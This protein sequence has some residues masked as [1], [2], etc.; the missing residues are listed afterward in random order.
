MTYVIQISRTGGPEV[1]EYAEVPA[2]KPGPGEALIRHTAV[3]LNFIDTY[4]RS[5]LYKLPLPA[6][7]GNEGAGVVE[8]VGPGVTVVKAGDRV[9]YQGAAGACASERTIAA[10]KLIVV[11]KDVDDR[12]A[13]AAFLKGVTA[14]Y[15][16]HRT[17]K[18]G[19]GTTILWHAAAGG[20]GQIGCQWAKALGATVIGT[21]GSDEKRA[22]AQ[23]VGCDHII[24]YR[25]EDYVAKV[26][27]ITGGAGVDVAYDSIGAD[28]FPATL[29]CIR[30]VGMWVSF[31]NASGPVP[32]FPP[33]LLMQKGS[34]FA[35]RPTTAHYFAQ[36][37]D[38]EHAASALFGAIATGKVKIAIGQ[39][40][41]L[42]DAAEAHRALEGR[43]TTGSTVL[44]P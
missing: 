14:Y 25:S 2:P 24:N 13:A 8:A 15:L 6:V 37:A 35:T 28:T 44:V 20:V 33:L 5:G 12:T 27:E 7:L 3:G 1:L 23:S 4:Q 11:P 29:D 32:P 30:P 40:F 34:L 9:V 43:R 31:G 39:S 10:E 18:A 41:A 19:P 17:F 22:L 16:L 26:K 36:R 38:L 42:K 21:V